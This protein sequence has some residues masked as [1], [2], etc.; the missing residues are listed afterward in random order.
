MRSARQDIQ[1][2][3]HLR[4]DCAATPVVSHVAKSGIEW[5]GL[6]G[7]GAFVS[8]ASPAEGPAPSL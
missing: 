6:K 1:P 7:I 4:Q 5:L 2:F 3:R 8:P